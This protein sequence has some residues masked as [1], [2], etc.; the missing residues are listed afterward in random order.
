ML[1]DIV[2][3]DLLSAKA[4]YGFWKANSSQDDILVFDDESPSGEIRLN[5]LRQQQDRGD[6]EYACLADFVAPLDSGK[7][8]H[9]GLFAVTAGIGADSLANS[10]RDSG[11]DY[12]ATMSNLLAD[13]FAEAAAEWLHKKVRHEWG[14]PDPEDITLDKI[15]KEEYRG[16]R[17]A[18]GYP[19]CPDHS[20][21]QKTFRLL[22]AKEI[23]MRLSENNAIIPAAGI[24]GLFFAHPESRYFSVGRISKEQVF[25]YSQRKGVGLQEAESILYGNL[26]YFDS[27]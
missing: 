18:Y 22:D 19:A 14:F 11:D 17:P 15:L 25:D 16:I 8:D 23:G 13:R 2:E 24:S 26:G 27:N 20:E 3:N 5:M 4:T 7:R 10:Y 9:I 6:S 12:R 1:E 21:M